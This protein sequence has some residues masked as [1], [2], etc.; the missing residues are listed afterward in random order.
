MDEDVDITPPPEISLLDAEPDPDHAPSSATFCDNLCAAIEAEKDA[1][2]EQEATLSDTPATPL[3]TAAALSSNL[4]P[5]QTPE[6][7]SPE[8]SAAAPGT[9]PPR[10]PLLSTQPSTP[11][12]RVVSAGTADSSPLR[13]TE[14]TPPSDSQT[15]SPAKRGRVSG[16]SQYQ[17]SPLS[18]KACCAELAGECVD[19][20]TLSDEEQKKEPVTIDCGSVEVDGLATHPLGT[21][22]GSATDVAEEPDA[23]SVSF[24]PSALGVICA[25]DEDFVTHIAPPEHDSESLLPSSSAS[26]LQSLFGSSCEGSPQALSAPATA[27]DGEALED[28]LEVLDALEVSSASDSSSTCDVQEEEEESG[29]SLL[30]IVSELALWSASAVSAFFARKV[31]ADPNLAVDDGDVEEIERGGNGGNGG[32]L[33]VLDSDE[34]LALVDAFCATLMDQVPRT[35][36][37][38][39]ALAWWDE[40]TA[41]L[42]QIV[43][44]EPPPIIADEEICFLDSTNAIPLTNESAESAELWAE[45]CSSEFMSKNAAVPAQGEISG[46]D[47]DWEQADFSGNAPWDANGSCGNIV[48]WIETPWGDESAFWGWKENTGETAVGVENRIWDENSA[49]ASELSDGSGF[50]GDCSTIYSVPDFLDPGPPVDGARFL[51]MSNDGVFDLPGPSEPSFAGLADDVSRGPTLLHASGPRLRSW[52]LPLRPV[53]TANTKSRFI[54]TRGAYMGPTIA[55]ETR[56]L[57]HAR[58]H[59]GLAV[60]SCP[61][62]ASARM[63]DAHRVVEEARPG[64]PMCVCEWN[65]CGEIISSFDSEHLSAHLREA[66][67]TD[68]ARKGIC[69]W[70][71]C[72]GRRVTRMLNHYRKVHMRAEE[73]QCVSCGEMFL[74]ASQLRAHLA[75]VS[76][77][78]RNLIRLLGGLDRAPSG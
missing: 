7:G 18:R 70:T 65:E 56:L 73:V 76:K 53:V 44:Y 52:N 5:P 47:F 36:S 19:E 72:R 11:R 33:A 66:H 4:D 37:V 35:G 59:L 16:T 61:W 28:E 38:S 51:P 42:A 14:N 55:E 69:Y 78:K 31:V 30:A 9:L 64:R 25:Y 60:P 62:P 2:Q 49:W 1:T 54:N 40:Q 26:P 10:S 32:E 39:D 12:H 34:A 74:D 67:D 43:G 6:E 63:S 68:S 46:F 77:S 57:D 21:D 75:V 45:L 13:G 29:T 48:D 41:E 24:D 23:Q 58:D 15:P 3:R 22:M 71:G 20:D 27:N 8:R 50:F 17:E